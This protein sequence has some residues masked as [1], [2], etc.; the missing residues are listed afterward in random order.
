MQSINLANNSTNPAKVDTE[1]SNTHTVLPPADNRLTIESLITQNTQ[2]YQAKDR[3]YKKFQI[4]ACN[5]LATLSGSIVGIVVANQQEKLD[6]QKYQIFGQNSCYLLFCSLPLFYQFAAKYFDYC[7]AKTPD[8]TSPTPDDCENPITQLS[9]LKFTPSQLLP[10]IFTNSAAA[11]TSA[12]INA[13]IRFAENNK[14]DNLNF[15][16][17]SLSAFTVNSI[18]SFLIN[19]NHQKEIANLNRAIQEKSN[20]LIGAIAPENRENPPPYISETDHP[21][22]QEQNDDRSIHHHGRPHLVTDNS[23]YQNN[24]QHNSFS[25][26]PLESRSTDYRRIDSNSTPPRTEEDLSLVLST[27]PNQPKL[28]ENL[29]QQ[30]KVM[31]STSH[32]DSPQPSEAQLDSRANQGKT[33]GLEPSDP[34]GQAATLGLQ[35]GFNA[36]A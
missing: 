36:Y 28:Y 7:K 25:P 33:P 8:S 17:I 23:T 22:I 4:P 18:V 12:G 27:R 3:I 10:Q 29:D 9:D 1:N 5:L 6:E 11:L 13:G 2:E 32:G 24:R 15:V 21:P 16:F 19:L 35:A 34:K 14:N 26:S 20:D 31:I 30:S